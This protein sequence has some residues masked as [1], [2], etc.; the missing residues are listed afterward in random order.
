MRVLWTLTAWQQYVSWQQSDL[1]ITAKINSFIED[2]RRD[3]VG[4]GTGQ[5]EFL[6]G[7]LHGFVSRRIT[8]EHRLVYRVWGTGAEQTIE[9]I[10]CR[11]HY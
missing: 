8:R 3:P 11:G 7:P 6:K 10:L 2:I 9:I 4:K 1:A 5:P